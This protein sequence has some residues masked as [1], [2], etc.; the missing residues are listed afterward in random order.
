[1]DLPEIQMLWVRGP[2][3]TLERLSIVS[4]LKNGHPVRLFSYEPIPNVPDGTVREDA[5]AIVP[6]AEIFT[7]PSV[8]GRGGLTVF[9]NFFRYKLLLQRGGIW[10]DCDSVCLKPLLFPAEHFFGTERM[11]Q[12]Q[13]G[14]PAARVNSGVFKT[15]A[16]AAVVAR[17]L[18]IAQGVDLVNAT[19]GSTGPAALHQAVIDT[20]LSDAMLAPAVFYPVNWW[21]I[22][23]LVAPEIHPVP[24][25]THAVHF[26]NEMW[27]RNFLDKNATYHPL[28]LYERLKHHYLDD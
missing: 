23:H 21:D 22:G 20:G 16:G 25:N 8:A 15:P 2:L 1:M 3:S 24:A 12:L 26:W 9:S 11:R 7:N 13:D 5:R 17:A 19:W 18:E 27:R 28:S 14:K 10:S 4:H 6:E